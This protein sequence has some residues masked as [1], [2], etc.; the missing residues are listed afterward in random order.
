VSVPRA[1]PHAAAGQQF[2]EFL[3]GKDGRAILARANVD[4][5]EH[6]HVVGDSAPAA[7]RMAAAP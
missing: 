7:L 2:V 5:L 6:P 1:A 4:A 3:L